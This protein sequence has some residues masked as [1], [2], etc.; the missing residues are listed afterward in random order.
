[1]NFSRVEFPRIRKRNDFKASVIRSICK[2][3]GMEFGP[4]SSLND[5]I[6]NKLDIYRSINWSGS[7]LRQHEVIR[8]HLETSILKILQYISAKLAYEIIDSKSAFLFLPH[9]LLKSK[10]PPPPYYIN[11]Y[12]TSYTEDLLS[13]IH[14][15]PREDMLN[16]L[17]IAQTWTKSR[18]RLYFPIMPHGGASD[19]SAI[20]LQVHKNF[21]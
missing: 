5:M 8:E 10:Q 15:N 4:E 20:L 16:L 14:E 11:V 1:M 7:T 6:F 19:Q 17:Y 12:Y 9:I 2:S 13:S 18:C 21:S 3:H